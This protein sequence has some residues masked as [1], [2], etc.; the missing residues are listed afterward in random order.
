MRPTSLTIVLDEIHG[1][2]IAST[3]HLLEPLLQKGISA[4]ATEQT[5]EQI[6]QAA[7]AQRYRL[8]AIYAADHPLPLLAAAATY[9][10][11]TNKG[12]VAVIDTIGGDRMSEWLDTVLDRFAALAKANGVKRIEIE[13]RL[14]WARKL[15]GFKP[16]R[17]I[18][19][20]EL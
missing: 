20:R 13:G 4:V 10:R 12:L 19:D 14:G 2:A 3:W 16:A 6:R 5:T 15:R 18:M 11:Q 17:I 1:E 9:E 7:E 8:W